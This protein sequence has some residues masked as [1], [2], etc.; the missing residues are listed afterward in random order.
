MFTFDSEF[1]KVQS[2]KTGKVMMKPEIAGHIIPVSRK[3]KMNLAGFLLFPFLF[4][5]RP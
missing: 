2:L 3:Q 5:I 4:S 1:K